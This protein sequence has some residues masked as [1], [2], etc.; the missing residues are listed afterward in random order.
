VADQGKG[1]I[2]KA[3]CMLWHM[4]TPRGNPIGNSNSSNN[5]NK[6]K[7]LI[8]LEAECRA[9]ELK[10]RIMAT[11]MMSQG[12]TYSQMVEGPPPW[13]S[14]SSTGPRHTARRPDCSHSGRGNCHTRGCRRAV[15]TTS[16]IVQKRYQNLATATGEARKAIKKRNSSCNEEEKSANNISDPPYETSNRKD[17]AKGVVNGKV[18]GEVGKVGKFYKV[19]KVEAGGVNGDV[20]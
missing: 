11:K 19:G 15:K 13:T 20:I 18:N 14:R 9:E 4:R 2:P 12:I 1:K 6:D 3:T 10:A 5:N 7:Y 17:A 16:S 8:R